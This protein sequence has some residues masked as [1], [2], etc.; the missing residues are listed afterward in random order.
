M[1]ILY[2][3]PYRQFDYLGQV[4]NSHINS[5]KEYS[6][7]T[8]ISLT[9]RPIYVDSMS[10][11][12]TQSS[13]I[14]YHENNI[15]EYYDII[16]QNV[17]LS[18]LSI[19]GT[20]KN[21]AVPIVSSCLYD[22]EHDDLFC[23]LD[24]FNYVFLE[25]T[26]TI[27]RKNNNIMLYTNEI[28]KSL[29]DIDKRYNI[30]YINNFFKFGFIGYYKPNKN[31]IYSIILSFLTSFR[32]TEEKA[33]IFHLLGSDNDQKELNDE[34]NN[35]K[36]LL[37]INNQIENVFFIFNKID[38]ENSMISLNTFDCYLSMNEDTRYSMYEKISLD[39]G[40]TILSRS[41]V[42]LLKSPQEIL[43]NTY[44]YGNIGNIDNA[45]LVIKMKMATEN[46]IKNK[47]NSYPSFGKTICKILS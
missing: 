37:N 18:Y 3:G 25:D 19:I 32:E 12:R 10:R 22:T 47:I 29:Y 20:T 33:L 24:D 41:N 5:I 14:E 36:K 16:I 35:I 7:D 13:I 38:L 42:S 26:K 17:P 34:Y 30:G 43:V 46:K 4:S 1:N 9:C 39:L 15:K 40:K 23:I 44:D 21:I 45:D 28:S 27:S 8:N 31:I 6:K 2:I 11:E